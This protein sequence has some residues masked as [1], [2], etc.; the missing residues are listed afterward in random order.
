MTSTA[1]DQPLFGDVPG[2]DRFMGRYSARL[3]EEF[4]RV[5]GV[6]PGQTVVDVGCGPGA[7][8]AVLAGIVGPESVAGVDPTESFVE[9]AKARVPGADLRV[10]SGEHLP[11]EVATFDRALSQLVFAFVS[12]PVAVASE[13]RRVTK[14]GG[15]AAA[16]MWDFTG[17]MTMMKAFWEAIA[18][19][20]PGG[21][22]RPPR[23]GGQPGELANLWRE[24][25][26]QD[27]EG[28]DLTVSADYGD[29]D[30]FMHALQSAAGPTGQRFAA[31]DAAARERLGEAIHRRLGSPEGAFSLEGTAFYALGVA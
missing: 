16:C 10:G 1:S 5:A 6:E 28:G 22:E 25:G 23:F 24:T 30:E 15:I 9:A 27:V 2:Y 29:F 17:R 20:D 3:A 7:L 12:D 31:L 14:P 8:T 4:A 11:F 13:M 21:E 19:V 26:F 18:E